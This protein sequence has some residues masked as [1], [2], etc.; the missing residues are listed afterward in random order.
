MRDD[1]GRP[2]V[3]NS[4][5]QFLK[6]MS[7]AGGALAAL[8]GVVV[9]SAAAVGSLPSRSGTQ[10][11]VEQDVIQIR[12]PKRL[13]ADHLVAE[14]IRVGEKGEYKPCIAK[15]RGNELILIN[16]LSDVQPLPNYLYRSLD[17]GRTWSSPDKTAIPAGGEPYLTRLKDGTLLLTGETSWGSRSE[18]GGR[19]WT[20]NLQ[21]Q[22]F[23]AKVVSILSRNI[24][25]MRDGS[26]LAIADVPVKGKAFQ[27]GN[28]FVARS[29][30]GGRTWAESY[31][32]S[33]EGVPSGYPWSIFA[34]AHLWQARSGK[35]YAVAR[36]DHRRYRIAGRKLSNLE[37]ASVAAE[38]FH[39]GYPLVKDISETEF[40]HLNHLKVYSSTDLGKTWQE[41]PDLGDYGIMYQ[42]ILRLRDGRLLLTFTR[43]SI[44]P[45]LGVRAVLGTETEDGFEFDFQH[46]L[47]MLDTK[48]PIGRGSGGGFGPTVQLDDG[49]LVTSYSYWSPDDQRRPN[50]WKTPGP[51][52]CEVVRWRL[53]AVK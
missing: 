28:E 31:P 5:R 53:P 8:P 43:R 13:G 22:E 48:T 34:E 10:P 25:Q 20:R 29:R 39:W 45:P 12:N 18:D 36:V 17:G 2:D 49:T 19:T 33:V 24:L 7:V 1:L 6:E 50:D 9:A 32:A 47:I 27:Y 51:T 41:G 21:P 4:R 44:D 11:R 37:M 14:R 30:D 46:D 3:K 26:L 16:Y 40:D 23:A 35:L 42:S 38:L 15:V 52:Q